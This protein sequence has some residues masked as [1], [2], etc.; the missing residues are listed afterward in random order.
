ME[1]KSRRKLTNPHRCVRS[2]NRFLIEI[3]LTIESVSE[4]EIGMRERPEVHGGRE[5]AESIPATKR[6]VVT[7][8]VAAWLRLSRLPFHSVGVFPFVLGTLLAWRITG[9]FRCSVF[10]LGIAG[11][12]L[13]MLSTYHSGEYFD[14]REDS[15]S[16]K[17]HGNPFAGG[18]RALQEGILP[19]AVALRTSQISLVLAAM[20][21]VILQFGLKTGPW[22]LFLG[23]IGLLCGFFYSTRPVRFVARGVGEL[24]IGFCYGW[25][26]IAA[27]FY[28]QT[29]Y[30]H[31]L[32]HWM[33]VPVGLTIFNVI[34]LNEFP[35]YPADMETEKKNLLVRAGLEKGAK[36]YAGAS[37]FAVAAFLFSLLRGVDARG[38][39][40]YGIIA[41]LS[42]YL[43]LQVYR[44]K[45]R[46]PRLLEIFCGLT[47]VVNLGTTLSYIVSLL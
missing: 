36:I 21:G 11:V 4:E 46:N 44:G 29:G 7:G 20:T 5:E 43:A 26:P 23:G 17:L 35:D 30:M 38:L 18:S 16:R 34:L 25:L 24:L 27:A 41:F 22:T 42:S 45:Y 14:R 8:K 13:V 15:L 9:E 33:A 12:V 40:L 19:P 6:S 31:P 32:I 37:F 3:P 39:Y 1:R 47:I 28:I 2:N 10:L